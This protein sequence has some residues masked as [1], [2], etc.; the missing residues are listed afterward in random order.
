[1]SAFLSPCRW[2][3]PLLVSIV[4]LSG[5]SSAAEDSP[6]S[7]APAGGLQQEVDGL[8]DQIKKLEGQLAGL[9]QEWNLAAGFL[10]P[11]GLPEGLPVLQSAVK[12]RPELMVGVDRVELIRA[13]DAVSPPM[14]TTG[15]KAAAREGS[16]APEVLYS[17][18]PNAIMLWGP[19]AKLEKG[20]YL[21]TYRFRFEGEPQQPPLD[22][23]FLDVAH[24]AVTNSAR[25]PPAADTPTAAWVEWAVPVSVPDQREFEFRF[26]PNGRLVAV[27]RIYVFRL[28]SGPEKCYSVMGASQTTGTWPLKDGMR[29]KD[30]LDGIRGPHPRGNPG[31]C[32]LHRQ[33]KGRTVTETLDLAADGGTK[34][35]ERDDIL[36]IPEK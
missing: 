14:K 15:G 27:D 35:L 10:N 7:P 33:V 5:L 25:K 20:R 9:H 21:V 24:K 19:Y 16:Y 26:W 12:N 29:V 17:G 28:Y 18:N 4:P 36:E 6:P 22:M 30:A 3:T 8:K 11:A 23:A 1:M 34:L 31:I 32:V 2:L 13:F